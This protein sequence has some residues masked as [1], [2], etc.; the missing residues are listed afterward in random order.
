V[1]GAYAR[2]VDLDRDGGDDHRLHAVHH[3]LHV[4]E[5]HALPGDV[6]DRAVRRVRHLPLYLPHS[7]SWR[8]R[9]PRRVG[10]EGPPTRDRY[11]PLRLDG[12]CVA[13]LLSVTALWRLH[14][15]SSAAR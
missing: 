4:A 2:P 12:A 7:P 1:F 14:T 8:R 6:A 5:A 3:N 13:V 11:C 9:Q 15:L 10:A